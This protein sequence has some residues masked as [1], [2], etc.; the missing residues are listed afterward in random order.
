MQPDATEELKSLL[1]ERIVCL[2]GAMG[3]TIRGYGLTEEEARGERFK[4]IDKDI[5]NNG[6]IL[7]LTRPDVILDIHKRFLTAGD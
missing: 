5:L 2:D 1:E 7:S 3:T 6:D 4:D